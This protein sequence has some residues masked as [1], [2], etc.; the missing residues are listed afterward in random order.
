MRLSRRTLSTVTVVVIVS[1]LGASVWWRLRPSGEP[2]EGGEG[3][4][5]VAGDPDSARASSLLNSAFST[6]IPQPVTGA[7]VVRDTLWL[8]VNAAGR[9]EAV[10]RATIKAQVAGVI[11]QLP[12]RENSGVEAGQVLLQL[13]ATEHGLAARGSNGFPERRVKEWEQRRG[14]ADLVPT[15]GLA[16]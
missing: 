6:D 11:E 10:H 5:V 4:I 8:S 3:G 13:E 7:K 2:P 15:A 16:A 1:V 14:G 9:A 12:A